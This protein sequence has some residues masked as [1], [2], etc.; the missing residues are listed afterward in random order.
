MPAEPLILTRPPLQAQAW[1]QSLAPLGVATRSLP[2][3]DT[4]ALDGAQAV[5]RTRAEAS[6]WAFFTSPAA[7][8]ALF[9]GGLPW[10]WPA[11]LRACCVGPGTAAALQA[12]G[13]PAQALLS[14]P[15]DAAQFDSEHLWPLLRTA[16]PWPARRMLWLCGEGGR[17]WLIQRLREAGADVELLPVY[18][19]VWPA[20]AS[21]LLA[22]A[23]GLPR[24]L[25]LFSSSEA[26]TH[27]QQIA[28]QIERVRHQAL[29]THPRIAEK[30]EALG[31]RCTVVAPQPPAV[32]TA[33]QA[34][35][36]G[37]AS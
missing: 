29:V 15:P 27:L 16:G 19:R 7:V 9:E 22:E 4:L 6:D 31:W 21:E 13:V 34:W 33:W 5:A 11:G 28:P 36:A 35:R 3:I 1:A 24:A 25:W 18:R 8:S 10:R 23:L 32:A 17:D 14:P 26:L 12:A 37:A 30:A 2:L 20:P